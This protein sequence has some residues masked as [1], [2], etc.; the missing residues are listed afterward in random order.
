M[1]N[2]QS[3]RGNAVFLVLIA[4]ALFAALAYAMTS[5]FRGGSGP[6]QEQSRLAAAEM[7]QYGNGLRIIMDKMMLMGGASDTNIFFAATG[8]HADYGVVGAQAATEIFHPS[9]GGAVYQAPP[10]EACLVVPCAYEFTGQYRINDVGNNFDKREL[11]MFVRNIPKSVCK[12]VN[13]ILQPGWTGI[14][15]GGSGALALVRFTGS[16][17]AGSTLSLSASL[18]GKRAFCFFED[19]TTGYVYL[20]VLRAR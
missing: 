10:P 3:T 11:T 4:M 6:T 15:N 5:G 20:H 16:Y 17:T 8:A 14:P 2:R 7:I 19:S 9:G 12:G 1:Q 13:K 18:T